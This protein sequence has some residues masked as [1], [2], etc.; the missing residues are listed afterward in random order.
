MD[1]VGERD[2]G[3]RIT[4]G[5]QAPV[6]EGFKR[7]YQPRSREVVLTGRHEPDIQSVSEQNLFFGVSRSLI[8]YFFVAHV[9]VRQDGNRIVAVSDQNHLGSFQT[10]KYD[11]KVLPRSIHGLS[12]AI[13]SSNTD[14]S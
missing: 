13:G 8:L 1:K 6:Q 7:S 3:D 9:T 14:I 4:G 10:K 12:R 11:H 5:T 2:I